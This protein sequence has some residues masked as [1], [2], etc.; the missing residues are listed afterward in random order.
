MKKD[1]NLGSMN[2]K[3][4][5]VT[6]VHACKEECAK[7]EGCVAFVTLAGSYNNYYSCWLKNKTQ[8]AE[9]AYLGTSTARM[10]CYEGKANI[11][12]KNTKPNLVTPNQ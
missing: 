12:I 4:I 7:T 11:I 6:T 2:I 8:G 5:F 1:I 3:H 9:V 10:S